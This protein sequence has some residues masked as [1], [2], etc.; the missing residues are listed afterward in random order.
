MTPPVVPPETGGGSPSRSP[1]AGVAEASVPSTSP[2]VSTGGASGGASES[3][4]TP[5][6]AVLGSP[7]GANCRST[8][9]AP[10]VHHVNPAGSQ[11]QCSASSSGTDDD[12]TCVA[13]DAPEASSAV[14]GATRFSSV[15]WKDI[16]DIVSAVTDST[17]QQVQGS[18]QS[19][20]LDLARLV[21]DWN[22]RP[23][24][25]T[26]YELDRRLK[27][28]ELLSGVVDALAPIP[29]SPAPWEDDISELRDDIASVEA[30]LA[31]SEASL[32]CEVDLLLKA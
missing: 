14:P 1:R 21:V 2:T 13:A 28:A 24:L 8:A 19:H 3:L 18:S 17:V 22:R 25:R 31:A 23:P 30:R 27:A 11:H 7:P 20:C 4:P 9:I 16:A 15:R 29:P 6:S 5:D 10:E 32:R 12:D 26:D